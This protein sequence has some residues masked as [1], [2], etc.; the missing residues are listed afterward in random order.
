MGCFSCHGHVLAAWGKFSAGVR[1]RVRM[2]IWVCLLHEPE[3]SGV[4]DSSGLVTQ[5]EQDI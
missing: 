3:P 2:R 1:A 5:S 4:V